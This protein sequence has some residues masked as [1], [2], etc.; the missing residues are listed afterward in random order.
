M[1][2]MQK[3]LYVRSF[4]QSLHEKLEEFAREQG[5]KPGTIVEDAL[6]KWIAQKKLVPRKHFAIIY[7]DEK[8]LLNFMKKIQD[9]TNE[10]E[11]SHTC[12]GPENHFALK[13]LRKNDW[14]DAS[15]KP[16]NPTEKS[17]YEYPK[18]V[19][20]KLQTMSKEKKTMFM[21]FMTEDFAHEKSLNVANKVEKLY[22][23]SKAIG[24]AFC[25]YRLE[26]VM[27]APLSDIFELIED[28]DKTLLLKDGKLFEWNFKE[29][30]PFKLIA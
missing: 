22:N 15:I 12:L 19:F 25:P 6:E 29:E 5:I 4:D 17:G 2:N 11:W 16:Y 9:A 30:N 3:T 14:L 18:K 13:Y 10:D 20:G 8:S 24:V 27:K 7:S 23:A 26:D 28:H 1:T 21:G